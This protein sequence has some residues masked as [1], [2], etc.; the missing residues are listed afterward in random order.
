M[1]SEFKQ[2]L[3]TVI[4]NLSDY[5]KLLKNMAGTEPA[6]E[7]LWKKAEDMA[8]AMPMTESIFEKIENADSS[9]ALDVYLQQDKYIRWLLSALDADRG[10]TILQKIAENSLTML[11]FVQMCEFHVYGTSIAKGLINDMNLLKKNNGDE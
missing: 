4:K 10:N 3:S 11:T 6:I 8:K 5:S 7:V 1:N 2:E 9:Y